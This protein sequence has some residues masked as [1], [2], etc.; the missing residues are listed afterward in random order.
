[1]TKSENPGGHDRRER[2]RK[3]RRAVRAAMDQGAFDLPRDF[4]VARKGAACSA[5][6]LLARHFGVSRQRI[7][8]ILQEE[9][10]R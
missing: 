10:R 6:T 1:M 4:K 3:M 2:T 5:T 7:H 8:Q 9:R